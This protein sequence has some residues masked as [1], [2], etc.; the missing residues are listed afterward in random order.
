MRT[1]RCGLLFLLFIGCGNTNEQATSEKSSY[2]VEKSFEY[3]P[4][5]PENGTL[6]AA[7]EIGSL[8]L[9]YFIVSIDA[10]DRWELISTEY[11]RSNLIFDNHDTGQ[12]IEEV[13]V[14]KKEIEGKGVKTENIHFLISSSAMNQKKNIAALRQQLKKLE[15]ITAPI[16]PA[17]EANYALQA[18]VPSEFATESF[19]V[20]IG[21]GNTKFSWTDGMDTIT[22]E[23]F[24]SKYYL[25]NT[26]DSLVFRQVRD[27][28]LDIPDKNRNL[29][30]LIGGMP[31]KFAE[32][33]NRKRG[34]YTILQSPSSYPKNG[35]SWTAGGV[36]YSA[37][38]LEPTYSYIFD[39]DSNFVIGYLMTVN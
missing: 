14:F 18:A 37:I 15:L 9:N 6:M 4:Q 36:I 19:L 5:K 12:L 17:M 38:Y 24:G 35:E 33:T 2:A 13:L 3:Q 26:P 21:S 34:R 27:I 39:W 29:C 16:S 1:F 25:S 28:I 30:F 7:V 32:H 10:E 22:R 20:D 11:G 23:S 8:G 31:Y